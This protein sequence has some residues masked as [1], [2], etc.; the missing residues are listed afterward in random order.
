MKCQCGRGEWGQEAEGG[1]GRA[2]GCPRMGLVP[3]DGKNW[4]GTFSL[5]KGSRVASREKMN[6][7]LLHPFVL[8]SGLLALIEFCVLLWIQFRYIG[9]Y[10]ICYEF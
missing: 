6:Q 10:R 2:G 8:G 3:G 9:V 5:G 7:L 1:E 4:S